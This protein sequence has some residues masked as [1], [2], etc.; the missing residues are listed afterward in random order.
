MSGSPLHPRRG[1]RGRRRNRALLRRACA[2]VRRARGAG[3][4]GAPRVRCALRRP[5]VSAGRD[6]RA[7]DG[8]HAAGTP[9]TACARTAPASATHAGRARG[10]PRR[11]AAGGKRPARGCG[12]DHPHVGNDG[13]AARGGAN[14]RGTDRVGAGLGGEPRMAAGRPLARV[15][16]ARA[17]RRAVDPHALPRR[18]PRRRARAGFRPG[19][20]SRA[21]RRRARDARLARADDA[22]ARPRRA[23]GLAAARAS[24]RGAGRRRAR[25][26]TTARARGVAA[27]AG[28][29]H[30]RHDRDLL[31]GR[32]DTLRRALRRRGVR[33]GPTARRRRTARGRRTHRGARPDAHGGLLGR[34]TARAGGL[35][36]YRRHGRDRRNAASCTCT[37]AA[38]T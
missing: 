18:A 26:G 36:R 17:R 6:R 31:A 13:H 33:R 21:A 16:A 24:S 7:R 32:R 5:P 12:G 9:R 29:G 19:R 4:R 22:R 23:S 27:R 8:D 25:A 34:A 38:A 11:C 3:R 10:A 35:V 15:H 1:R 14:A 2:L 37:R 28:R 20:V 30:L